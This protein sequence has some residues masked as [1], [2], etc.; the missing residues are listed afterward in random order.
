MTKGVFNGYFDRYTGDTDTVCF[1]CD[2][3]YH[4]QTDCWTPH[5]PGLSE[6]RNLHSW[7]ATAKMSNVRCGI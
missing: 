5:C 7:E 3:Y 6:M 4:L 1:I 2:S